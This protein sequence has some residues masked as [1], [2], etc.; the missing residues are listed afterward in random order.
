MPQPYK[1]HEDSIS[2]LKRIREQLGLFKSS[3]PASP[4]HVNEADD[5]DFAKANTK[6]E[7]HCF[8]TYPAMMIAPVARRLI[9]MFAKKGSVVIDPFCGSGTVLVEALKEGIEAWGIDINPLAL[10][11]ARAKTTVLDVNILRRHAIKLLDIYNQHR[12]RIKTDREAIQIPQFFNIEYWFRPA[13]SRQLAFLRERLFAI[14]DLQIREFFLVPFSETV[15]AASY[16]RNDEFKLFR[17]P[18]NELA[19]HD[20]NVGELFFSKVYRN[21]NGMAELAAKVNAPSK[22]TILQED[23]RKRTSVP[24]R[25]V[26]LVVTSPPYGDSRTTVAYGQFSR[27]S[28]QWLGLPWEEAREIDKVSLGGIRI[29]N[30]DNNG[31]QSQTLRTVASKIV[32]KDSRRALDVTSFYHDLTL[33]LME[34]NRVCRKGAT[35]C[36]VVGNRTVKGICIP[37]DKIILEIGERLGFKHAR[38]FHRNIPNKRMPLKNS[39]SN[40]V[41][42]L[43]ETMTREYIVI[44]EKVEEAV[45]N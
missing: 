24:S 32:Q 7:T 8:H 29:S 4:K 15:R 2:D 27:L 12:E 23:T 33:C 42:A 20:P 19:S 38:T 16:T 28:L 30:S 13:V 36:F 9:R 43:G 25:S 10:L 35:I 17:I 5:W 45:A 44:L 1:S 3:A 37:T 18:S 14:R 41:G 6:T 31:Y 26:N 11:I 40:V 34:I 22:I 21:L 39:P